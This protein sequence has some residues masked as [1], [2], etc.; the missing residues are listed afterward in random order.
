MQLW[1]TVEESLYLSWSAF[2]TG[3]KLEDFYAEQLA[4]AS[5]LT[6]TVENYSHPVKNKPGDYILRGDD[7]P[8]AYLYS[9][10]VDLSA[11][12]GKTVTVLVAP[13]PNNHFAFPAYYVLSVE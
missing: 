3:K 7:S 2:H 8:A 9:T 5:V 4:N 11:Y 10:R 1:D 6:G 12:I 13:R